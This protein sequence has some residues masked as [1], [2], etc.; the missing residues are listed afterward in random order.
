MSGEH[1]FTMCAP[2]N[3]K[4]CG[5]GLF[6]ILVC[7]RLYMYTYAR[8]KHIEAAY[9][10]TPPHASAGAKGKPEANIK[11]QKQRQGLQAR[12]STPSLIRI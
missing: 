1:F 8:N 6:R 5:K 3:N 12:Y 11:K 7:Q 4:V 10:F 2:Q 9:V